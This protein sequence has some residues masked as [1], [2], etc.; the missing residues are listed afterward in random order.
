MISLD[1]L[2][3]LR[4]QI[5]RIRNNSH[6]TIALPIPGKHEYVW[7]S[8]NQILAVPFADLELVIYTNAGMSFFL[9]GLLVIEE[10]PQIYEAFN[11]P[12]KPEYLINEK[13]AEEILSG[14]TRTL[15]RALYQAPKANK[16]LL[17]RTALN[18]R[19]IDVPKNELFKS[20][21][22][23]DVLAAI[24]AEEKFKESSEKVATSKTITRTGSN[25]L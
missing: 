3:K 19:L 4:A 16:D 23:I 12:V 7:T 8:Y 2:T 24:Q 1:E 6:R 9:D 11:L 25:S 13:K 10:G 20:Y 5:V 15:E 17:W 22:G 18:K 14:D 21:C